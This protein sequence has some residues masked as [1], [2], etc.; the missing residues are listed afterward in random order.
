VF[1]I[2]AILHD[3]D[4][5]RRSENGEEV[6]GWTEMITVLRYL[7][8]VVDFL[9]YGCPLGFGWIKRSKYLVGNCLSTD[10]FNI[11]LRDLRFLEEEF[12][13]HRDKVR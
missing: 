3:L 9:E 13:F 2:W 11:D 4:I 6:G 8:L 10:I 1:R 5:A 12:F 7:L